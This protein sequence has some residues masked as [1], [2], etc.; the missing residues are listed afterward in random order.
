MSFSFKFLLFKKQNQFF[1]TLFYSYKTSFTVKKT[2]LNFFSFKKSTIKNIKIEKKKK[3]NNFLV[4]NAWILKMVFKLDSTLDSCIF[5][6]TNL[7]KKKKKK[8]EFVKNTLSELNFF[9]FCPLNCKKKALIYSAF[10]KFIKAYPTLHL[11]YY[12]ER[13]IT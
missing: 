9:H 2:G 13:I 7:Q 11:F 8:K 4:H 1:K 6:W 5:Q 3:K 12:F 10:M